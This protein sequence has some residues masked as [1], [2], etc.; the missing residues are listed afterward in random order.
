MNL[1][2]TEHKVA[3][4]IEGMA[5]VGF[6][7]K[8]VLYV[9]IGALAVMAAL[10]QGGSAS[11]DK[12]EV[13]TKIY[14]APFGRAMVAMLA[15]GLAGYA[16][17][18]IIEGIRDPEHRG[19]DAKGIA[20]RTGSILG[21]L[22]HL[23]LAGAA[24]SLVLWQS[25][26]GKG[27]GEQAEH[28]SARALSYPGGVYVLWAVAGTLLAYGAYQLFRAFKKDVDK[29]LHVHGLGDTG[30]KIIFGVSR[31]GI[32]ARGIVFGTIGVLFATAA[33]SHNP[34]ESGG[35]ADSMQ[36]LV[37]L[38]KWP[39]FAIAAGVVAYGLYQFICAKYRRIEC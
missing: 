37:Q 28:W 1:A 10:G 11:T 15:L 3:P 13:L 23:A 20:L 35:L 31:F 39:F 8:G 33:R 38:G 34:S 6:V 27:E 2:M 22:I 32:A 7:A 26:G 19:K 14:D 30:R 5:R 4:W 16:L 21:G 17:W 9:T 18:R 24:A 25:G 29:H 12:H 36:R